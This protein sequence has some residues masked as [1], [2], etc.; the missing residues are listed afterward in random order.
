MGSKPTRTIGKAVLSI[1]LLSILLSVALCMGGAIWLGVGLERRNLD[2]K[3]MNAALM[4][5]QSPFVIDSLETQ[6]SRPEMIQFLENSIHSVSDIDTIVVADSQNIQLYHPNPE[7]IGQP[8]QGKVQQR[9]FDGEGPF[10]SDDTGS[11]GAERCA[12]APIYGQDNL[13]LGFAMVGI[14]IRSLS[15]I[16]H[17][18]TAQYI[19]LGFLAVILGFFLSQ[20]LSK[21]I[22]SA[23]L[24]YE[25]EV[26][27]NLFQQRSDILDALE[28]GI[29]AIDRDH[30]VMYVNHAASEILGGAVSNVI[31]KPLSQAFP[32]SVLDRVM[33]TRR[34]EYYV[35]LSAATQKPILANRLPILENGKPVGA[36][37]IFRDRSEVARLAE[38]LTGA[39]H[40][41]EAMRAYTHEFMNKLHVLMG[42][43]QLQEYQQ[44]EDYIME[45]ARIQK[46]AVGA[47]TA[48]VEDPSAAA[49]LIGKTSR[50]SELGIKLSLELSSHLSGGNAFLPSEAYVTILGNLIE[51][52]IEAL[53]QTSRTP[54]E[55]LVGLLE[56]GDTLLISVDDTGPGMSPE[57]TQR[58]FHQGYSTKSKH[59][60]TGLALVKEI[61]DAYQGTI[62]VESALGTGTSFIITFHRRGK[63]SEA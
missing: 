55:I 45:T 31:G 25:P 47:I 40:M 1:N 34:A 50:A 35:D 10:N 20:Q 13:L 58:I 4:V 36:V 9:I 43:L 63:E 59:R 62:R 52:A 23:L 57:A 19:F 37:A 14:N 46:E 24:G 39:K 32:G 30:R 11:S 51:N 5:A 49:L 17:S 21:R 33:R 18:I 15:G 16:I 22:K 2:E 56:K 3:L 28:E 42:L 61:V 44:A 6:T 7:L 8:Y 54:K 29:L 27:G 48:R 60:G 38:D 26:I 53:N 41:V 12:Y